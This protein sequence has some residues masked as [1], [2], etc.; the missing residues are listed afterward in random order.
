MASALSTFLTPARKIAKLRLAF[1]RAAFFHLIQGGI[2]TV[3]RE[4]RR[5]GL[6]VLEG[7]SEMNAPVKAVCNL[8]DRVY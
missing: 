8:P 4:I 3:L 5:E 7:E 2:V 6:E 1:H